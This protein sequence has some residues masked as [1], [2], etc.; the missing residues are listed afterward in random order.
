MKCRFN[1][2]EWGL[3]LWNRRWGFVSVVQQR[4]EKQGGTQW[5][6]SHFQSQLFS[7]F[8]T[9]STWWNFAQI[10]IGINNHHMHYFQTVIVHNPHVCFSHTMF[11]LC[12]VGKCHCLCSS[13]KMSPSPASEVVAIVL[14][15][16][17][18]PREVLQKLNVVDPPM[19]WRKT[20]VCPCCSGNPAG[21]GDTTDDVCLPL[22]TRT[23]NDSPWLPWLCGRVS[24]PIASP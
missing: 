16:H 13:T 24:V 17:L 23:A 5:L 6:G 12:L 1:R 9:R 11:S 7:F 8:V 3:D 18:E 20:N 22:L 4:E 2:Q 14:P 15:F 21:C 19:V 10:W